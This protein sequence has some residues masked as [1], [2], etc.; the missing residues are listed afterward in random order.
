[1]KPYV[2]A[3]QFKLHSFLIS[4]QDRV[5]FSFTL[6]PRFRWHSVHRGLSYAQRLSR[7]YRK[8]NIS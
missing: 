1:M 3:F 8:R 6:Q 2:E 4:A 7:N 5:E